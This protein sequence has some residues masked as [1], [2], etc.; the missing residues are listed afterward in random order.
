[1]ERLSCLQ[2]IQRVEES[3]YPH[4]FSEAALPEAIYSELEAS[5]PEEQIL[6]RVQQLDGGSPTRRLKTPEALAWS[7]L[8]PIWEDFLRFHTSAEYLRAVVRLFEPQLV[9]CLGP[10]RLQRL[11]NG[12]VAPRRM[13]GPSDLVTDCQFVLNDPIGGASTNQPPH[14]DNPKE[15]YAGLLYM[16]SPLDQAAGGEFTLHRL[17]QRIRRLDKAIGRQLSPAL[18]TPLQSLPYRRNCFVMFLNT[19]GA[20]HSVTPRLDPVVRRRSIN[21]IGQ[22]AGRER[23]WRIPEFDSRSSRLRQ[24]G[25]LARTGWRRPLGRGG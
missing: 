18:H 19:F 21:I 9:R 3:P 10:K 4:V 6:D 23:M 15:I 14:V 20:V 5:F 2:S 24:L 16:R 1:M 12:S 8:P 11:L 25:Q 17:D 13:G 7:D 22:Y